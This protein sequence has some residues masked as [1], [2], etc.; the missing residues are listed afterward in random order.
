[1]PQLDEMIDALLAP[2]VPL[3]GG[4]NL[5]IEPTAALV[6]IDVNGGASGNPTATNLL[7]VREVARQIRLR[8]LGGIIVIDCL[9]MTS[10]ADASKV[11]NAFERVAASDPAGI[12]CYGL[13]KL[14]LLEATRTRR[15]QPLSSVVGNE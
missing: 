11:V 13:N 6:A 1:H 14:G 12:H 9:K 2:V 10:R 3:T 4:A 15:G 7:A 5:I 8:N